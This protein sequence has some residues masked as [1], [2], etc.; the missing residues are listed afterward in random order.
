MIQISGESMGGITVK[1]DFR[2]ILKILGD[3]LSEKGS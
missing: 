3:A 2:N 1:L